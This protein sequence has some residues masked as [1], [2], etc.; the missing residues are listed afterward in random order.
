MTPAPGP[1]PARFDP[2]LAALVHGA[3][4]AFLHRGHERALRLPDRY[5]AWLVS[6]LLHW[7]T[8]GLY[9]LPPPPVHDAELL[10][11]LTRL[12]A[13]F[14]TAARRRRLAGTGTGTGT[15]QQVCLYIYACA[16]CASLPDAWTDRPLL[17]NCTLHEQ[18]GAAEEAQADFALRALERQLVEKAL[19][20]SRAILQHLPFPPCGTHDAR[21]GESEGNEDGGK[22]GTHAKRPA[23]SSSSASEA[24]SADQGQGQASGLGLVDRLAE[25]D[26]ACKTFLDFLAPADLAAAQQVCV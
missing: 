12:V 22:G 23:A 15:E 7:T 21:H 13:R 16:R 25:V 26:A 2:R 18:G 1:D 17:I 24:T 5:F 9:G 14:A 19:M 11:G 4:R 3:F 10:E 6:H 8:A 20:D